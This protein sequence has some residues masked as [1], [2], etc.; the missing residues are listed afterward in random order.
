[1]FN[2]KRLPIPD[3]SPL[4]IITG[5][6]TGADRAGLDASYR[7]RIPTSGY[8][9]RGCKTE[10]GPDFTLRRYN[11]VEHDSDKYPPRTIANIQHADVTVILSP[12]R[13]SK[14][15][16]LA[17]ETCIEFNKPHIILSALDKKDESDALTFFHFFPHRII[18]IAGNRESACPGLH[19]AAGKFLMNT[20]SRHLKEKGWLKPDIT[21]RAP[22]HFSI[23]G[24]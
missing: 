10:N 7:L 21:R 15:T 23:T 24:G 19:V 4:T 16:A 6:Q 1:M 3:N 20:L 8:V 11:V 17:L 9:P 5:G 22:G 13:N 14:G 18:N 2:M 12:Q